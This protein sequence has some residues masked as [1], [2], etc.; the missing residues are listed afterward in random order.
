MWM[1]IRFSYLNIFPHIEVLLYLFPSCY[2]ISFYALLL[3][4]SQNIEG[5]YFEC[6]WDSEWKIQDYLG[7]VAKEIILLIYLT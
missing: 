2:N 5:F 4:I 7:N 6:S 1:K 3:N